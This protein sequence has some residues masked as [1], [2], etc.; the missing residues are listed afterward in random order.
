MSGVNCAVGLLIIRTTVDYDIE[1]GKAGESR[2]SEESLV[3]AIN[4]AT[5]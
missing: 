3:D 4:V 2:T 5:Q 1:F